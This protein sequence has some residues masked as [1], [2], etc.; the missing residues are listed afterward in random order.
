MYASEGALALIATELGNEVSFL[1]EIFY[2]YPTSKI[3]GSEAS[4]VISWMHMFWRRRKTTH[5][6]RHLSD[7]KF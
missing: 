3:L 2:G 6:Y 5:P 7:S 4:A 1:A